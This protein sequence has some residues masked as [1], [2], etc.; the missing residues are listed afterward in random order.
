[1]TFV[2]NFDS[3]ETG[4]ILGDLPKAGDWQEQRPAPLTPTEMPR[5]V[6]SGSFYHDGEMIREVENTQSGLAIE[7]P[8]WWFSTATTSEY[9]GV[10]IPLPEAA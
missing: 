1:M 3:N 9:P 10:D 8:S 5:P 4:N 6:F 7:I 2:G